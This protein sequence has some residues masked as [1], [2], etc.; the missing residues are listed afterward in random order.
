M[1]KEPKRNKLVLTEGKRVPEN[2]PFANLC[3]RLARKTYGV[4]K[5]KKKC[6]IRKILLLS[7]TL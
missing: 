7:D 4:S 1:V 3:L 5:G 6:R 2:E